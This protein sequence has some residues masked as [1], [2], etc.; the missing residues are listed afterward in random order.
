MTPLISGVLTL[1]SMFFNRSS[2]G[3]GKAASAQSG[4]SGSVEAGPAAVVSLS[5]DAQTIARFAEQGITVS[6]RPLEA[7]LT[8]TRATGG[9]AGAAGPAAGRDA[10]VS[11]ADFQKLLTQFGATD[12]ER[13]AITAGFD[14]DHDGSVTQSEFLKGLAATQGEQGGS[15]GS[16]ALM[17]LMD[18]QGNG[19]G[20][21]SAKEFALFTTA[22]ADLQLQSRRAA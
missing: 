4:S 8:R 12:D 11:T 5:K 21:I 22:F 14:A 9:A 20:E 15:A 16:Q 10:A 2:S 18:R 7:Q 13:A 1:S 19:N 3:D 17:R 6:S